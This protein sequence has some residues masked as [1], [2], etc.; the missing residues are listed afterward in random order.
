MIKAGSVFMVQ[1]DGYPE[2]LTTAY[3]G[4]QF[5]VLDSNYQ[6]H[7]PAFYEL[8]NKS[9]IT[10]I[11]TKENVYYV[12]DMFQPLL[13]AMDLKYLPPYLRYFHCDDTTGDFIVLASPEQHTYKIIRLLSEAE[14]ELINEKIEKY[15]VEN[16]I[17]PVALY[18]FTRSPYA[19]KSCDLSRQYSVWWEADRISLDNEL[20]NR[21]VDLSVKGYTNI[22]ASET[23]GFDDGKSTYY[24]NKYDRMDSFFPLQETSYF[25][26]EILGANAISCEPKTWFGYKQFRKTFCEM[27]GCI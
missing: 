20:R 16:R 21:L 3:M 15:Y 18:R 14:E 19:T 2:I 22:M 25:I 10:K 13:T 5:V 4:K 9:N 24:I 8:D 7:Y 26:N 17:V 27:E 6:V 12:L 1:G 23:M 11:S